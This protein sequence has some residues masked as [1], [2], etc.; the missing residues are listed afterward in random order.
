[1]LLSDLTLVIAQSQIKLFTMFYLVITSKKKF[2]VHSF[3][4]NC[5]VATLLDLIHILKHFL[6]A[7]G[8]R[9]PAFW[10]IHYSNGVSTLLQWKK[11]NV[12]E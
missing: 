3:F 7:T 2:N 5:Y 4:I 1:M 6:K 10:A 9:L 11:W 8:Q 12:H